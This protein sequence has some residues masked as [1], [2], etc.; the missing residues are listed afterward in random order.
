MGNSVDRSTD[1]VVDKAVNKT[2]DNITDKA[3]NKA[4]EKLNN[5]FRKKNKKHTDTIPATVLDSNRTAIK[6]KNQ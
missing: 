2:A 1:K 3:L 5:L 6:P 4:G